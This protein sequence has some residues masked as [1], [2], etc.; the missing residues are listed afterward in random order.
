[1]VTIEDTPPKPSQPSDP[2]AT[3]AT[4]SSSGV[5]AA[6]APAPPGH[7]LRRSFTVDESRRR[8]SFNHL[9]SGNASLDHPRRRSSNHT[10]YSLGDA[11]DLLR[12]HSTI[13]DDSSPSESSPISYAPTAFALLPAIAGLFIKNGSAYATDLMLLGIAAIFLHWSVTQPW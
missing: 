5:S 2:H 10:D 6:T 3:K 9:S 7:G 1:M 12:H 4:A 8:P 13:A 11:R